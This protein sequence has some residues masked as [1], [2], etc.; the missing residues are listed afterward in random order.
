MAINYKEEEP[1][2]E[3]YLGYGC[4]SQSCYILIFDPA[5]P[6]TYTVEII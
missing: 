4:G 1:R 3:D 6:Q 5:Y 2:L